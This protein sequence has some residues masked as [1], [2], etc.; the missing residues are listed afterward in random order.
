MNAEKTPSTV[1]RQLKFDTPSPHPTNETLATTSSTSTTIPTSVTSSSSRVNDNDSSA[2]R[3][4]RRRPRLRKVASR[5][6]DVGSGKKGGLEKEGARS[7]RMGGKE[8]GERVRA[9]GGGG[10]SDS[11]QR[12]LGGRRRKVRDGGG[13][14][15]KVG[16]I[17]G[18]RR[19][20]VRGE[21]L[22]NRDVRG[23]RKGDR[24]DGLVEYRGMKI[25]REDYER[26]LESELWQWS[27]IAFQAEEV[28]KR[29]QE[30]LGKKMVEEWESL[31]EASGERDLLKEELEQLKVDAVRAEYGKSC[32]HHLEDLA[33][34]LCKMKRNFSDMCKESIRGGEFAEVLSV[35]STPDQVEE[36]LCQF[37]ETARAWVSIAEKERIVASTAPQM[38]E[39][40]RVAGNSQVEELKSA[41]DLSSQLAD[42]L[43]KTLCIHSGKATMAREQHLMTPPQLKL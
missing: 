41:S 13:I 9:G 37:S 11:S 36:A 35:D 40:A 28:Y 23:S 25:G 19:R 30:E 20:E 38:K 15:R 12:V 24:E 14:G 27:L 10:K 26:A 39:L 33:D 3:P 31:N 8:A 6:R 43:A 5:F 22:R 7:G 32:L 34:V 1:T 16:E 18:S 17:G 4:V 2:G 42:Q 29:E 21:D